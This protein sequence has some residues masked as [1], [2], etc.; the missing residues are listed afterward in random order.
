M[1]GSREDE[2]SGPLGVRNPG[3]FF[4]SPR[5]SACAW[6]FRGLFCLPAGDKWENPRN[7]KGGHISPTG[8]LHQEAKEQSQMR[9]KLN[10]KSGVFP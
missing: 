2:G 7:G 8:P 5:P 4:W 1:K 9:R 10:A 3:V 6:V